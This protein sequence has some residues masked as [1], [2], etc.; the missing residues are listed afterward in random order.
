MKRQ[1]VRSRL[2]SA[3]QLFAM[4]CGCTRPR[5]T[6]SRGGVGRVREADRE[7]ERQRETERQRDRQSETK[8]ER[9][10][11]RERETE[12]LT[13]GGTRHTH[14]TEGELD[15]DKVLQETRIRH[16]VREKERPAAHCR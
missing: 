14:K 8:T 2:S 9:E 13:R 7:R 10:R 3:Q 4:A 6:Q 12:A 11:E 5:H 16:T 15:R 1:A